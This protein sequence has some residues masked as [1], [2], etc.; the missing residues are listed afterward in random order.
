[1]NS[2]AVE[3]TSNG[4]RKTLNKYKPEQAIS[5]FVRN[6]FDAKATIVSIDFI[7]NE[8]E[9]DT[10]AEIKITD[11]GTGICYEEL[12]EKFKKF[13]ESDKSVNSDNRIDF[14][15]GKNGY[16]RFTFFKFAGNAEWQT[17][18]KRGNNLISYNINIS[19]E[20]LKNY[21]PTTPEVCNKQ[22]GNCQSF[23]CSPKNYQ[24]VSPHQLIFVVFHS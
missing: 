20:N 15:R 13:H 23:L 4:I 9:F 24:K 2:I 12:S 19:S 21:V 1:M 3:I 7:P 16:G 10:Y 14:T 22:Q 18:Y 6:G 17:V 11:N 5:E 8:K